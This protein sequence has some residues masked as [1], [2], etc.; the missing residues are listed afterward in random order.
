MDF[1][2]TE[3]QEKFRQ[4]IHRFLEERLAP[5]VEDIESA[6]QFPINFYKDLA[7]HHLLGIN[8]PKE[9]GGQEADCMTCA[10][11]IEEISKFSSGVA[12][13]VT[14]AGM[15]SPAL[16]LLSG[17]KEQKEKYLHGV[18][19][20]ETIGAFAI[21]E[22]DAGSDVTKLSTRAVAEGNAYRIHGTKTFITNG[23]VANIFLVVARTGD[24]EKRFS[25]FLIE[26]GT[27]GFSV[28]KKFDKLGWASQDTTEISLDDVMVPKENLVGPEGGGL[29]PA[30]S[31][32]NFTR[33]LLSSTAL[34]VA[35]STLDHALAYAKNKKQMGQ[36]LTK[37][38]GIRSQLAKM[39]VEVDAARFLVYRAAW[40]YDRGLR[41][42]K[43][44]AMAKFYATELAK[45]ITKEMLR[46][47]G[48]DGFSKKHQA[49]VFFSDA[50]VFAIADG[51]S[52]IQLENISREL[53][54]L[55]SGGMGS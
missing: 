49:A 12:G 10:L 42:R 48:L 52:E 22:P 37:Q 9:Y 6:H 17:T 33:I 46:L 32:V 45:R 27:P 2:L 30:L 36:S 47:H 55:E 25:V 31:M 43:E 20:G 39:A 26:R 4:R 15:T 7:G 34:G 40:M 24:E 14:T 51:T 44:T 38:Q 1:S 19:T 11:L 41:N 3:E 23:S 5:W 54:L 28:S 13:C 21:T 29:F 8:F 50:P 16:L 18:A 53:G 35:E